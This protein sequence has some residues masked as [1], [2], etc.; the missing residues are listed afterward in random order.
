MKNPMRILI[1]GG[2]GTLGQPLV[3]ELRSRNFEVWFCDKYQYHDPNYIKCD[4]G[5]YRVVERMFQKKKFDFVYH[6]AAEFGRINGEDF[7]ETLWKTN[8]IG[9]K[10]IIHMQ[11]KFN[12]KLVFS[13]SSE[14][15]GDYQGLMTEDLPLKM[16][17]RQLNDYGITK[18]VNE[19]QIM[20]SEDLND[21]ETV[22]LRLFNVYGPGEYYSKY[23]SV[24]CL[25]IYQALHNM[26]YTVYLNHRRCSSF[27][28]DTIR[29]IAN[30]SDNFHP[31]EVYNISGDEY[32]DIK[33]LS[34]TILNE[35]GKKDDL[36][37][38]IEEEFHNILEKKA[39]NFKAKKD[40]GHKP[41]ISLKEGIKK[42]IE[43]Q[44]KIYNSEG[45]YKGKKD[46][47]YAPK[48]PIKK[49]IRR[50]IEGQ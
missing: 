39:D 2:L 19:Q 35:L 46:F 26:P 41:T 27:I 43:W 3:K 5:E 38:Y 17:L 42:T 21:V 22:R 44:K 28:D 40:L 12:F 4:I 1:T 29:T 25:F 24:I 18:W 36:V 13:S 32:H 7:F 45:S 8:V 16:P 37:E 34:D 30:V 14:I 20:N 15:Y 9:T 31:G 33:I 49:G 23:R 11:L 6:L 50:I 48:I 47:E 10:N